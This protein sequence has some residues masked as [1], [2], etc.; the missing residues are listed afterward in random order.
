MTGASC[1]GAT[2]PVTLTW[3]LK[4]ADPSGPSSPSAVS[5]ANTVTLTIWYLVKLAEPSVAF[6]TEPLAIP[7]NSSLY[8]MVPSTRQV[9]FTLT[10][11]SRSVTVVLAVMLSRVFGAAGLNIGVVTLGAVFALMSLLA[12]FVVPSSMPSFGVTAHVH[13]SFFA[14]SLALMVPAPRV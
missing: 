4:R 2:L 3:A 14:V 13:S 9:K 12:F 7:V 8:L 11:V 5:F 6:T 1:V 10:V